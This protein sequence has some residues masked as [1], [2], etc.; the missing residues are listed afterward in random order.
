VLDCSSEAYNPCPSDALP[1]SA[2]TPV[3]HENTVQTYR[4][5]L[6]CGV[7][8]TE[9]PTPATSCNHTGQV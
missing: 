5:W 8:A 1:A 7:L 4:S 6:S 2:Q 9:V 3:L